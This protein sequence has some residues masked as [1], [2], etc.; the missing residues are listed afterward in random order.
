MMVLTFALL[1]LLA[2]WTSAAQR[3]PGLITLSTF[4]DLVEDYLV[5]LSLRLKSYTIHL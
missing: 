5:D 1:V 2:S 4:V 3:K